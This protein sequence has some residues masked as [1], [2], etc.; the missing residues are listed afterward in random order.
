MTKIK[1]AIVG[2]GGMGRRWAKVADLH[3]A[4]CVKLIIDS[5]DSKSK[6][7]KEQL[8]CD[9]SS[10]LGALAS[11][12]INAVVI[13][14]PNVFLAPI[15]KFALQNGKHVLC[16]KPAGISCEEIRENTKIS[17]EKCLTY[18][19]GF[20][21]RFHPAIVMAKRFVSLNI[22]GKIH[23]I[24]GV[25]GH[26]GRIGY[27][28]EWRSKRELAGGGELLDQ[29]VHLIDLAFWFLEDSFE[30]VTG[31]LAKNFWSQSLED[32]AFI[33]LQTR[34]QVTVSLHASWTQW[35]KKFL[36][37]IYG[38]KGIINIEGLG[39]NYGIE[40]LTYRKKHPLTGNL[41]IENRFE[42][43]PKK[44]YEDPDISLFSLWDKFVKS[45][46][47]E[48]QMPISPS[49]KDAGRVL[50]IIEAIYKQ[51]GGMGA[52]KGKPE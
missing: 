4:S 21:H 35:Q 15:S 8:K 34:S 32:N 5:D 18:M 46:K 14:T 31:I 20:N 27:D 17:S 50:K 48:S 39:G 47:S 3:K 40:S 28:K 2:L 23:F 42:F 30:K 24:R 29:G 44:G 6:E 45:I 52:M 41:G 12:E 19:V 38:E 1:V 13:A 36:W 49:S 43:P 37:E 7:V 51:E 10:D 16:E 33:A 25:Y 11:P 22:I 26:G 9:F